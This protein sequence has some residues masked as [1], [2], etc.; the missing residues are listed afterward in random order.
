MTSSRQFNPGAAQTIQEQAAVWAMRDMGRPTDS[1]LVAAREAW[2]NERPEHREA[3]TEAVRALGIVAANRADPAVLALR[4]KALDARPMKPIPSPLGTRLAAGLAV[5]ALV[6]AIGVGLRISDTRTQRLD[7]GIQ[8]P[9][10]RVGRVYSTGVGQ[11]LTVPLPDGSLVTLDTASTV[12]VRYTVGERSVDLLQGQAL[13]KVAKHLPAPFEVYAGD[14]RIT[15]LGTVFDV[16]LEPDRVKVALLEGSVRVASASPTDSAEPRREVVLDPGQALEQRGSIVR[17]SDINPKRT[18]SWIDGVLD[19]DDEPLASAVAE[20]N[21]YSEHKIILEGAEI[22]A[23]RISGIFTTGDTER[24]AQ[25]M[26]ELFSL[27]VAHDTSGRIILSRRL[28]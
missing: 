8:T 5:G 25:T 4:H 7:A 18:N 6:T 16:R 13:F 10:A 20:V 28:S 23:L 11:R 1:R 21:R 9:L 27:D 15:A 26:A 3:Y 14:Q 24:F 19:F 17:V 12:R 22:R 2:L